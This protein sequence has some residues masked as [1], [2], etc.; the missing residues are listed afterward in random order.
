M[1]WWNDTSDDVKGFMV[2]AVMIV[3]LAVCAVV[4]NCFKYANQVSP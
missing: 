1:K 3:L 2:F 4:E